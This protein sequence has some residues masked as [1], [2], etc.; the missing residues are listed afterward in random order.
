MLDAL[1]FVAS[2]VAKKDYVPELMHFKIRDERVTGFNGIVA[3]SSDIGVD[4]N[5]CPNAAKLIAA[6]RACPDETIALNM[7]AT[8]RLAI[9]SGAFKSFIDCLPDEPAVWVEPEGVEIEISEHFLPGI[10][11]VAPLMG[12]DASRPWAMGIRVSGQSLFVTNNTMLVE[13]WIGDNFP[14]DVVIPAAAIAEL[15]RIDEHPTKVQL[16]E[17]SISF[18]FGEN[19]WMRS[20]LVESSGWPQDI[21]S[22]ILAGLTKESIAAQAPFVDGF[23]EAVETL[24]PF[25]EEAGTIFIDPGKLGT[26]KNEGEG[27]SVDITTGVEMMQAY[28]HRNLMLLSEVATTIDWST[29]PKPC[30]FMSDRLRGAIVGQR[31]D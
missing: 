18:W 8:G 16:T 25:V 19:R 14:L 21:V 12:V 24:K 7:T 27:T 2:A 31:V 15:I 30:Y 1:R 29:Y 5:T 10:K 13:Y 23:F 9:K 26:S 4:I 6:I 17:N 11:R 3:L 22:R 20:Q 28:H